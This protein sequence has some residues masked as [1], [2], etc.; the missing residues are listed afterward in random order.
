MIVECSL[1]GLMKLIGK[2][3]TV[4]KLE[5]TLFLLKAEVE[6]IKGDTIEIEIN[7]D[8]PDMLSAEG[9]A[10]TVRAF[11]GLTSETA[12]FPVKKSR[13]QVVVGKGLNKIRQ[14][15]ACAI[16]KDIQTSDELIK[17]Y[18]N[19]QE[20]L[21]STHGRNRRKAS[22]G[23]YVL[24]EIKFPIRY[25]LE[26][27][28]KIRFA[29]LGH[30]IEMDGP[31]IMT[32]HEKGIEF[33]PIVSSFNKW[34]FLT[35]SDGEVLSLPPVINSN[36]LGRVTEETPNLFIEVTGT[37]LPTV[38][39][40]L[41]IMVT[42]LAERG[43]KIESLTVLYP[44][45]TKQETPDLKPRKIKITS[46]DVTSL[47]GLILTDTEVV[48][49]LGRM[50]YG[51]K[52]STKGKFVVEIPPYRTDVL[53]PVDVI[54]DIA[55]GYGFDNI[56]PTMPATMTAGK[57]LPETRLKNKARDLMIGL[58]YQEI[59]SYILTA[60]ETLSTKM[61]RTDPYVETSNP[62][63]RDFSVLRNSLLPILI[64]FA[65]QN[66]HADYPQKVF[67][68]GDIVIPDETK[69]TRV[70]QL[71]ALC[72]ILTDIKVNITE[73][74]TEIG[75]LLRNIGLEGKFHYKSK[76]I[77]GFIEGR[78]SEIIIGKKMI[79]YLGEISPEVLTK[80]GI[81]KPI[82]GFELFIPKDGEW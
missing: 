79:G 65:A 39:Q 49:C 51:T 21:T 43:G 27:P 14:F 40:C 35:D 46:S 82:V 64:D 36:N 76:K 68:V 30:D 72:G 74:L 55:I 62:K 9:I 31:R 11:L 69:E 61:L 71:P 42:S 77:S 3:L 25:Y 8:R 60:P 37:H 7:P 38:N 50:C 23:L 5:D 47:T 41:N 66:Q 53:H 48:D 81:G 29:P 4:K 12:I 2:K 10:R 54:E 58:G 80:F 59:L 34:P 28:E 52:I 33:G 20:A 78:S 17:T 1:R 18:M 15:I 19:L 63:S 22:I 16:V 56:I 70:R 75:F 44:D 6:K 32:E 13:K 73:L 67:E 45:D 26:K 57:L 24:D